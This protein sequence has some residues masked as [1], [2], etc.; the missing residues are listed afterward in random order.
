MRSLRT[1]SFAPILSATTKRLPSSRRTSLGSGGPRGNGP[2]ERGGERS[3]CFVSIRTIRME[4]NSA[5]RFAC[6]NQAGYLRSCCVMNVAQLSNKTAGSRSTCRRDPPL[7]RLI[8]KRRPA[9]TASHSSNDIHLCQVYEG[10]S[11]SAQIFRDCFLVVFVEGS[12]FT[13]SV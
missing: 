2:D 11:S 10:P 1:P 7:M 9:R 5:L 12:E 8:A 3:A 4:Q 6:T 13:A